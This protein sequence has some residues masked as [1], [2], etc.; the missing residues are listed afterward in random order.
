[1]VHSGEDRNQDLPGRA[2]GY[3]VDNGSLIPYRYFDM[4]YVVGAGS[5]Y[6]TVED[7]YKWDRAL[8]R[9]DFIN[10]KSLQAMLAIQHYG[11]GFGFGTG[12]FHIPSHEIVIIVLSNFHDTPTQMIMP[13]V[14]TILLKN[15]PIKLDRSTLDKYVGTYQ[16]E[17]Q[18]YLGKKHKIIIKR[19]RGYLLMAIPGLFPVESKLLPETR[20]RFLSKYG[21][22]YSGITAEFPGN[23]KS[24]VDKIVVNIFGYELKAYRVNE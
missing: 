10:K 15:R 13:Q 7:V 23:D 2:K 12:F 20:F 18:S 14:V 6:S 16:M 3:I 5:I 9:H 8:Y 17:S 11:R 1:M 22:Y 4:T 19:R 21:K 24:E